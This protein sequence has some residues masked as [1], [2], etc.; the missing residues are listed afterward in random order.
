M[1]REI[2]QTE[3]QFNEE[4]E[5]FQVKLFVNGTYQP[6]ADYYT[7][8]ADDARVTAELMEHPR[9]PQG[10]FCKE[11]ESESESDLTPK[12][13]KLITDW[14]IHEAESGELIGWIDMPEELELPETL[15]IQ[16]KAYVK[17]SL[18]RVLC[19]GIKTKPEE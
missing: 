4:L 18:P 15:C 16:D 9:A 5:E 8:D 14:P 13:K 12:L 17:V 7:D 10:D 19:P 1:S 2:R 3:I 11:S 6:M